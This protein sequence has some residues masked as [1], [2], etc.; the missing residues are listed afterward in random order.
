MNVLAAQTFNGANGG[1]RPVGFPMIE[2][3]P[4]LIAQVQLAFQHVTD[5]AGERGIFLGSLSP[6]PQKRLIGDPDGYV[7]AHE[8]SVARKKCKMLLATDEHG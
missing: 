4:V 7:S 6:S 3:P 8:N 2:G 1:Q 5:Q